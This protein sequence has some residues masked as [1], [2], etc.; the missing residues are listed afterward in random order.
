MQPVDIT[1]VANANYPIK[2]NLYGNTN[3]SRILNITHK[4]SN[5]MT[6]VILI[7]SNVPDMYSACLYNYSATLLILNI[8]NCSCQ[9]SSS[10]KHYF[11]QSFEIHINGPNISAN[12]NWTN[13]RGFIFQLKSEY[14]TL[15]HCSL[16]DPS[17][18]SIQFLSL[19]YLST[20][21]PHI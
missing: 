6:R 14:Q 1:F 15:Q 5:S 16:L 8:T 20:L 4:E 21:Q 2:T 17:S 11:N 18:I 3:F 12:H 9:H 19:T 7:D 13:W 10:M